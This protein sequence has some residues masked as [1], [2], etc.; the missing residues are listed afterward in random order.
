M[1]TVMFDGNNAPRLINTDN[2]SNGND[3]G[4]NAASTADNTSALES[5]KGDGGR[6]GRTRLDGM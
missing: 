4:K 2:I 6:R 5:K 3:R 1:Q